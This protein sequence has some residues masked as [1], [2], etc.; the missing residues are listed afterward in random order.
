MLDLVVNERLTIPSRDL[1]WRSAAH[2]VPAG[3][4]QHHRFPRVAARR[5]ELQ[6]SG[7]ISPR[8]TAGAF[9]VG[10]W[11]VVCGLW[12][13]RTLSGGPSKALHRMGELLRGLAAT[14]ALSQS[15]QAWTRC[16]E[17]AFGHEEKRGPQAS[18]AQ[19]TL[20]TINWKR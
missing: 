16:G 13:L 5:G 6:L 10:W 18:T 17:A 11:R 1:H 15:H 9:S 12:P 7:F 19:P 14:A 2:P 3:R 8:S 20:L 4:G